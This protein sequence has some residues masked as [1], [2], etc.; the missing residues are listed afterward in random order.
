GGPAAIAAQAVDPHFKNG[1]LVSYNLNIQHNVAGITVQAPNLGSQRRPLRNNRDYKQG[2]KQNRPIARF[3]H[4]HL[5]QT[6]TNSHY[7]GL[8]LSVDRKFTRG[9]TFSSSYTFSKSID[10][11]SVGSSNPEAQ[12]FRNLRAER[13]LSDFDTRHRFVLSGTY[14]LP[15]NAEGPFFG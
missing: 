6:T 1:R 8:W 2:I 4:T 11:N 10:N 3:L 14:A 12:D 15:F 9:L 13:A 5:N 7:D